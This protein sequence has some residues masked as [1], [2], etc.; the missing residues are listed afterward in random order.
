MSLKVQSFYLRN[1]Q[2][3]DSYLARPGNYL[4][5]PAWTQQRA[6]GAG[7]YAKYMG[8]LPGRAQA[9]ATNTWGT[10]PDPA[11]VALGFVQFCSD[12]LQQQ[13]VAAGPW[14]V[15]FG[16][17]L[18]NAA[19]NFAW[20]GAAALHV[21]NGLTGA[22]RA[23]VFNLLSVGA[24]RADADERTVFQQLAGQAFEIFTG[25]W[26]QLELGILVNNNGA[27]AT[28]PQATIFCDGTTAITGDNLATASAQAALYAPVPFVLSVPQPGEQ[29]GASVTYE[30]A[31]ALVRSFWP[32]ASFHDFDDP[33]SPDAQLLAFIAQALKTFAWDMNDL[34]EREM[35]PSRAVLKLQDWRQLYSMA[36][37]PRDPEELRALVIARLREYGAEPNIFNVA[38]AVGVVLGY[39][40]PQQVEFLEISAEQLRAACEYLDTLPGA[41]IAIPIAVGFDPPAAPLTRLTPWNYDGGAVWGSGARVELGFNAPAGTAIRARLTGPDGTRKE[42]TPITLWDPRSTVVLYA[43]EF[44]G[45]AVHGRWRLDLYRT[46]GIAASLLSWRLLAPG[47]P[48]AY[49]GPSVTPPTTWP[50]PKS[51]P[52]VVRQAGLA[53]WKFW[54]GVFADPAKLSAKTAADFGAARQALSRMRLAPCKADLILSKAPIPDASTSLPDSCVPS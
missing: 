52:N 3:A 38:A 48:R 54:W 9:A 46:G 41:G 50:Q 36:Q 18:A 2:A 39:A 51:V 43:P 42:W 34:M 37:N 20:A 44:A 32:R 1:G 47:A 12:P 15:A 28:V 10:V 35:D 26:L 45:K 19:F 33:S 53:Q 23:T 7:T 25:D 22:R 21:I 11:N 8:P 16:A 4:A 27:G 24:F 5:A 14:T 30:E 13:S 40:D 17:R 49:V 6:L 31:R 29:P